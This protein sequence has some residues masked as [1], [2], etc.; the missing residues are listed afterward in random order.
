MR[1]AAQA[2]EAVR[3]WHAEVTTAALAFEARWTMVAL[4]LHDPE[5]AN[6][7]ERAHNLFL[8]AC[9]NG[10]AYKIAIQGRE[11]CELYAVAAAVLTAAGIP[12]DAYQIG[13]CPRT[14]TTVAI[15][16]NKA[17]L[18][19]VRELHGDKVIYL[20]PDEVAILFGSIEA[21]KSIGAIKLQWPGAD[22]TGAKEKRP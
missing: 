20:S 21:F 2:G 6:R 13:R 12:D 10:A 5:Q 15:G 14:G 3:K 22:L 19:R 17:C 4:G 11:L 1:Q 8:E 7:L 9:V 16:E 18:H